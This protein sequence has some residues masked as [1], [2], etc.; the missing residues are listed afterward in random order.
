MIS[1]NFGYLVKQTV[2]SRAYG[3]LHTLNVQSIDCVKW[4]WSLHL[5]TCQL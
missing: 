2:N 1:N 4:L 5:D 3:I